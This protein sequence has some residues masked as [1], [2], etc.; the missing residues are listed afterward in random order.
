MAIGAAAIVLQTWPYVPIFTETTLLLKSVSR[1][2]CL[3]ALGGVG[4]DVFVEP[5]AEDAAATRV[6]EEEN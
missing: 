1:R 4:T 3:C 2:C 6:S 5:S